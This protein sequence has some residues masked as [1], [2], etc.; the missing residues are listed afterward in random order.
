M[1]RH[2]RWYMYSFEAP[3]LSAFASFARNVLRSAVARIA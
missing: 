1:D 3:A 2:S